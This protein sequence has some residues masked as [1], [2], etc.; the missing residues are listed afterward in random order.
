MAAT[1]QACVTRALGA[2]RRDIFLQYVLEVLILGVI[3]GAISIYISKA[4]LT[5][6]VW[7]YLSNLPPEFKQ[8]QE[9]GFSD[10]PYVQFDT[11]MLIITFCLAIAA[12]VLSALYP[13][14]RACRIA[15]AEYLKL[16]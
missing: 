11:T 16:N 6:M 10:S 9:T 5:A 14:W 4:A 15:P 12:A 3:G 13:A 2:T 7:V 8:V 1:P